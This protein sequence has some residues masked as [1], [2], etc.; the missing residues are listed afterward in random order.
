M[1]GLKRLFR[2]MLII[3][4]TPILLF[5]ILAV[6]LYC[7]PVQNWAV[8][9]AS[10]YLSEQTGLNVKVGHVE[11]R[12]PLDLGATDIEVTRTDSLTHQTD[13]I[14]RLGELT[15]SVRLRPLFEKMVVVDAFELRDLRL[16]THDLIPDVRVDG[17]VGRLFVRSNG[18][19]L[20]KELLHVNKAKLED[21]KVRVELSD[22]VPPDTT[23]SETKWR[24]LV[25]DLSITHTDADVLLPG[26]K[27]RIRGYM[28]NTTAAN[29]YL[30]L[31]EKLYRV[32]SFDWHGGT[33][34]Y[35]DNSYPR[36][37]GLDTNHVMLTDLNIGVD[38]LTWHDPSLDLNVRQ[39]SMK[40]NGSGVVVKEFRG[41]VAFNSKRLNLPDIHLKTSDSEL[42]AE[43]AMD[44]NAFDKINPGTMTV[45]VN[46]QVGKQD[47]LRLAGDLPGGL[48]R[49]W[50][51]Y[52]LTIVGTAHGNMQRLNI[53]G[54]NLKLPSAFNVRANGTITNVTEPSRMVAKLNVDAHTYNTDF[55]T[56]AMPADVRKQVRIP[57]G[58]NLKG[59]FTVRKDYYTGDFTVSEGGGSISGTAQVDTRG[60]MTYKA[61]V[62]ASAFPI[63]HFLPGM[64]LGP[65]TGNLDING[66]GTD[67]KSPSTNIDLK[68][69]IVK[70][71]YDKWNLDAMDLDGHIAN[72]RAT[73]KLIS[74]NPLVKGNVNLT[75]VLTGQNISADVKADLDKID[76]YHLRLVDQ[77]MLVAFKGD[78]TLG[79]KN[80]KLY[81]V[82][83]KV[84]RLDLRMTNAHYTVDGQLNID[85]DLDEYYKVKGDIYSLNITDGDK[86]YSPESMT[87]DILTR[88]DTTTA[89]IDCS[90]LH[91][92]LK[93][94]GGY[95]KLL[96]QTDVLWA[97]LQKQLKNKKIDQPSIFRHLPDMSLYLTSGNDNILARVAAANGYLFESLLIDI[98]TSPTTGIN[99]NVNANTLVLVSDSI[100]LDT[101]RLELLSDSLGLAY[102]AQVR[103]NADNPKYVFNALA[104][105]HLTENGSNVNARLYDEN[106]RLGFKV[107]V[108]ASIVEG[109]VRFQLNDHSPILGYATFNVNEDNYIYIGDD[110]RVSANLQLLS[111]QGTGLQVY[112]NDENTDALQDLTLTVYNLDIAK[113]M[114]ALPFLPGI[115][116]V[117]NG[118]Y[119]VIL[120]KDELSVSSSMSID[121]FAIDNSYIGNVAADFVYVP[122]SDGS[123]YLDGLLAQD[124]REVATVK[125]TYRSENGGYLDANVELARTPLQLLNGFIPDRIFALEGYGEGNLDI[126]GPLS[127]LD[128]NGEVYLDESSLV[129]EPYSV[130]LRFANDPVRIVNSHL[131]FENF[132]I[133]AS[134]DSPL[135]VKG[136]IDFSNM[137]NVTMNVRMRTQNFQI[138]DSKENPRSEIYGKAFVNFFGSMRGPLDNLTL[139][140]KLDV[141]GTT[142]MTYVLKESA[143]TT[144][145]QLDELVKFTD[146]ND[147]TQLTV[148]RPVLTGFNMNLS[149][150]IDEAARIVCALNADHSNY[151]DLIGGG[152]L[153]MTYN[154][155]NSFRLEG[156]YTLANGEMKYSLPVIPLKTFTIKDGSYIEFTGDPMNPTLNITATQRTKAA[157]SDGSANGRIV[158]FECGVEMTKT[159]SNPGIK[160]IIDAPEDMTT[161]NSL[162]T[163]SEEERGKIAVTM[164]VSGMY[165]A[166]GNTSAVTMNSALGAFLQN[167]I[168]TI[169]GNALHSIGLDVGI[170]MENSTD[171]MGNLHTDYSFKFSKRLWDNRLRIIMGGK[172]STGSTAGQDNGAFFDNLTIEYR[173]DKNSSK[174]LKAYYKRDA[175][176]WLDGY[177]SEFGVGFL[178]RRKGDHFGD[179]LR[180][181]SDKKQTMPTMR[182]HTTDSLRNTNGVATEQKDTIR[183]SK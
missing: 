15:V 24:I 8:D 5:L 3:C 100:Q 41:P 66:R 81:N 117:L 148:N 85:T 83:G 65:F 162:N 39:L 77:P 124:G 145:N 111:K 18:I 87:V 102:K 16:N 26:G 115:K 172:V 1:K 44:M 161:Q 166:D 182:P 68:A 156:K 28:E 80:N 56:S 165:L 33:L 175:Y 75:A 157:V 57:N 159:L 17:D 4:V 37:K 48:S 60:Q 112:T 2:A 6:L 46:G 71:K 101:V 120:T 114:K 170:N 22:T 129:S 12:F 67:I 95:K 79:T 51:N 142:D 34:N 76:L 163:M 153:R 11:L 180:F 116:G 143:L 136:D 106:D 160:F 151:I 82:T 181:K 78:V 69:N 147:S 27:Q 169:T 93:A 36:Q 90:D 134:N 137:D 139:R 72:G 107:G 118:D 19:D 183:H 47:I 127:K 113:Q 31:K 177:M 25:D 97:D 122:H 7:P 146:F 174:Y 130:K 133:F 21:A 58:I 40:E 54:L 10:E 70:F 155:V 110:K 125:G 150:S 86:Q 52:P 168:N 98:D 135:N 105:G 9:K 73:A 64:D 103:N 108:L 123:H 158:E 96:K 55:L 138:I 152:D 94:K 178:W 49:S 14:A 104:D 126:K 176:D 61:N 29:T 144:D 167:E 89:I 50:P 59:N 141:L 23:K 43:F 119:H 84:Q 179:I 13:S 154:N 35:D 149:V 121:K 63:H 38:S 20:K 131:L 173:L 109:G 91:L 171:A 99:G 30:D 128:I 53:G 74:R 92:D 88:R 132:E 42:N 140:G 62:K 32:G 45:K 164:L